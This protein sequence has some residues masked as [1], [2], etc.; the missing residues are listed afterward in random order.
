MRRLLFL[1]ADPGVPVLGH[2]GA[3]I[4]LRELCAAFAEAGVDVHIASPRI[5]PEARRRSSRSS[6][7]VR[8]LMPPGVSARA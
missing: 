5:G 4:H 6:G 7:T 2:K 1:T 8:T 3:S